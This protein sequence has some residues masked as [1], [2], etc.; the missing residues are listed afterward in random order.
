MVTELSKHFQVVPFSGIPP[1]KPDP[2]Q[3]DS[4]RPESYS[5][6]LRLAA[7]KGANDMS[8]NVREAAKGARDVAANIHGVSQVSH[9]NSASAQ[10][11]NASARQL[12]DIAQELQRLVGQFRIEEKTA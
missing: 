2:A 12:A 11:V 8:A 4:L 9:D 1:A 10:K 3:T 7:A 5:R 6:L